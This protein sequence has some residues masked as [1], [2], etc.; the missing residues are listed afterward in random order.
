MIRPLHF[1]YNPETAVNNA[2]QVKDYSHPHPGQPH[3]GQPHSLHAQAV[4]EFD[5]FVTALRQHDLDITVIQDT[6][7][8]PATPDSLFPNNW[9]SFH[10]AG[11]ICLYPMFAVNRRHERKPAVLRQLR[12]ELGVKTTLDLSEH[13]KSGRFLEGT[14]SMVLDREQKIAYACLSP[15]TDV[16]VLNDFC[17][18]VRK[19]GRRTEFTS[20]L[21]TTIKSIDKKADI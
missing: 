6:P 21:T 12:E 3:S 16:T 20:H 1:A 14:G 19:E 2:F 7:N 10:P 9:I 13:E 18:K 8:H 17:Q 11:L 5:G 15:R 4:L